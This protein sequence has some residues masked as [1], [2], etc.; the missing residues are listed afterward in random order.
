[1]KILNIFLIIII[2]LFISAGSLFAGEPEYENESSDTYI[3]DESFSNNWNGWYIGS[4]YNRSMDIIDGEYVFEHLRQESSWSTWNNNLLIDYSQDFVLDVTTRKIYGYDNHGYGIMFGLDDGDNYFSFIISGDGHYRYAKFENNEYIPIIEWTASEFINKYNSTN[5]L[6][7]KRN[8]SQ[9]QF[10]INDYYVDEVSFPNVYGSKIGLKINKDILV[11][12]DNLV[13]HK[14]DLVDDYLSSLD[15]NDFMRENT[16]FYESFEDN[17]NNWWEGELEGN[18]IYLAYGEYIYSRSREEGASVIWNGNLTIDYSSDFVIDAKARKISGVEDHGYGIVWGL[19]DADNR[20]EFCISDNGQYYYGY[21]YDGTYYSIIDWTESDHIIK[22]NA[23]NIITVEKLGQTVRFY[24][25][26]NYVAQADYYAAYG[27]K[28]G[29]LINSSITVAFDDLIAYIPVSKDYDLDPFGLGE[30]DTS[31]LPLYSD[32][33]SFN[34]NSWYIISDE[35][36]SFNLENGEFVFEHKREDGGWIQWNDNIPFDHSKDFTIE[37]DLRKVRGD[38]SKGYGIIFGVENADNKY[39]FKIVGD[40]EYYY[41]KNIDNVWTAVIPHSSST[42]INKSN[43]TNKIKI[44]KK[45]GFLNFYINDNW[46][47]SAPYDSDFGNMMGFAVQ[48]AQT[49]AY[50]NLKI[51]ASPIDKKKVDEIIA[52][53]V[54]ALPPDLVIKD[55][56]F[57]EPSGNRALDGLEKGNITFKLEN[58]G[59]GNAHNIKVNL[60]PLT[61]TEHLTFNANYQINKLAKKSNEV[62]TIPITAAYGIQSRTNQFR[63]EVTEGYG[64]YADPA[65]LT[66]ETQSFDPPELRIDK[67]AIDD[68]EDAEG[69]GYSYGN[70]NSIIEAGESIEV[71]AYVQNFGLGDADN[72]TARIK[73]DTDDQHITFPN[74]NK[75][76]NLGDISSGDYRKIEFYFYTSRAYSADNIPITVEISEAKGKFGNNFDLGLK[77]GIRTANVLDVQ[78]DRIQTN[79]GDLNI[80]QIEGLVEKADVDLDIPTGKVD[81]KNILAIIIGIEKYKYAPPVDFAGNDAQIFYQYAKNVFRIPDPNIY[82]RINE[83]ATSGE[84]KK[85]FAENGWI[86]RRLQENKTEIIIYY[87]GHGAPDPRSQKAYLI[88]SDIDPNYAT[89]GFSLEEMYASISKLKAKSVTVFIDACFSGESRAEQMLIAGVRP[90][91]ISIEDPTI[92]ANNL[93]VITASGGKQFSASYPDKG[94]GLFTYFLLKGL[95]GE[96]KGDNDKLT[97][98]ELYDYVHNNVKETA[99]Y[100][101]KE[102]TPTFFGGNKK[103]VLVKY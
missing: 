35:N 14:P 66:F 22:Y 41:G 61:S 87:A 65:V 3:F 36:K 19:S 12:Y 71:T 56:K 50:D 47:N 102:Q 26:D 67:I 95:R 74:N 29:F 33:Y 20:F 68:K 62:V 58:K 40:G 5:K 10:Y 4:D 37:C 92:V 90:I 32:D 38:D 73:L 23:A 31:A 80:R 44:V 97:L 89:T 28:V 79:R 55:L 85:I 94:H 43:S 15:F 2:A 1:V 82:Y 69:E 83:G 34:K 100:L 54:Q 59:R 42:I 60:A 98:D 101:D 91:G 25:N 13:A 93:A 64:F 45:D 11:A 99:G 103:K 39:D 70:G 8:G 86:A 53:P 77:A 76:V 52:D 46:M 16:L 96:A 57:T 6:T 78:V 48:G 21:R 7:L 18:N 84:F 24:I 81:G 30:Y 9:L 49:I 51:F 17:R 72:V 75:Q 88:P 27:N 63:I